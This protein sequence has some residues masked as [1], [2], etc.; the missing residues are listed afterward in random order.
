MSPLLE[1]ER[2]EKSFGQGLVLADLSLSV[3][4]G[5]NVL[6]NGPSGSGKSTLLR[7]IAG[8]ESPSKGTIR[9]QGR[10]ASQNRRVLVPASRRGIAMVFQDL[11]LWSNLTVRQNVLLG[12]AGTPLDRR[13]KNQRIQEVL[14]TCHIES[15]AGAQPSRLSVGE[16]QRVALARA[17][18]VRPKI[19]LLDEPFTGLD[20]ALKR[21]LLKPV[22]ELW[23]QH[24]TTVMLVSHHAPDAF[25]LSAALVTL[26]NGRITETS[27]ADSIPTLTRREA[28]GSE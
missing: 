27:G 5:K 9:I 14:E 28:I 21:S 4:P 16:Q 18:A 2:I 19:L 23:Q 1:I 6:L 11:G 25:P 12:L 7:V 24:G 17:I 26:E 3:L 15:K 13:E 10:L 8:L 20:P 22:L